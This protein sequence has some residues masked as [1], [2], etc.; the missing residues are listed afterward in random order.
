ME[1]DFE[2]PDFKATGDKAIDLQAKLDNFKMDIT[3]DADGQSDQR[4]K[5]NADM[6]FIYATGGMWEDFLG[7]EFD[8]RTKLEFDQV[9]DFVNRFLGEWNQNRVGVEYQPEDA[10]TSDEDAELLNGIYRADFRDESGKL[11]VDNA[12]DEAVTCGYGAFKLATKFIDEENPENEHQRVE[13]RPIYNAYN[14]VYWARAA[15]RIDKRDA[16]HC[17][18]LETFT[19]ESFR[20][21]YG[22]NEDAVSAYTPHTRSFNDFSAR[23]TDIIYIA[24]RYE[25]VKKKVKFHIYSN[26]NTNEVESYSEEDHK[27][28]EQELKADKFRKKIRERMMIQQSIEKSV[29]SGAKFLQEP[30]KIAGKYIPIVPIYAYHSYVDGAEHYHGLVRKL[31]D[32]QRLLNMQM[33]Q[34]AENSAS[35]GQEVPIFDPDQMPKNIA[36]LWAD[37]NNKPYMLAKSLT[38]ADGNIVHSGPI[39]TLTPPQL[40][41][42][43]AALIQIVPQLIQQATGGAPQD[44]ID[45]DASGKAIM[46]LQKR[47]NLKTQVIMDNIANSI[48]WSGEIYQAIAGVIYNSTRMMRVIGVDGTQSQT[49]LFKEMLDKESGRIIQGNTLRGRKFRAYAS[50]GPQYDSLREQTVED[51]KGMMELIANTGQAGAKYLPVMISLMLENMEGVGLKPIKDMV[52]RDMIAQGIKNPETDEEKKMM[53]Q[54]QE[55]AQQPDPQQQLIEAAAKQAESEAVKFQSEARNL[56]SKSVDNIASARKK[57][58]ETRKILSEVGVAKDKAL[59]DLIKLPLERAED[60]PFG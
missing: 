5:A 9:S 1:Q 4:D 31:M 34:L 17:T 40:D 13:F 36:A 59:T 30:K 21:V 39:G 2:T 41:G 27:D 18:V 37:R 43:T 54:L 42:S 24:T 45:P 47:E 38:D 50:T 56:D 53:V 20:E 15:K 49:K 46:A 8:N 7:N 44:T 51:M 35:S 22:E 60:L 33:S 16:R 48:E 52:R 58:A 19:L 10:K 12:V 26:I 6:R 28:L 55:Q 23:K 29:F 32:P 25:V 3:N 14:S 11:A 57:A